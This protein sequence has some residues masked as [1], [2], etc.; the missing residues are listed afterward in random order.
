MGNL[1]R[2]RKQVVEMGAVWIVERIYVPGREELP[3]VE[4]F[5]QEQAAIGRMGQLIEEVEGKRF[6]ENELRRMVREG[7][8]Y[9]L[10]V[11][12]KME[13]AEVYRKLYDLI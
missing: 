11:K 2:L 4:G 10:V 8:F 9:S 13:T 3:V 1:A 5:E 6:A 7:G 12:V